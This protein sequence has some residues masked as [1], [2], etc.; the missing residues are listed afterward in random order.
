MTLS[1]P[2]SSIAQDVEATAR[3]AKGADPG[4]P[5][6]VL[7][8][9]LNYAPELVGCA[10][11][12]TEL[13]EELVARGHVV[14]V[15][16]APPYYPQWKI[17]EPYSGARWSREVRSG[18]TINRT[19]LYVPSA[20]SGVKRIL[21]LASFGAAALPTAVRA[22]KRFRPDLVFAVAPTLAAAGAALAAGKAAGAKTWLHVQDFEVDAAFGLGLLNNGAAR[23]LALGMENWL[24]RRFDRVSSIAPA[25][26]NLL[27]TKGVAADQA[28]ELR[29]W[30]DLDAFPT[31]VSSDTAYR[32]QLGIAADQI[33]ALYSGNMAG[34][35]GIEALADVAKSLKAVKAP[36]T[37]LLCGEGPARATLESAC[38]GLANVKFLPLQPLERLPEL[39]AT[40]DIHLLPQRAEAAD[41][42]LP[43]KLTGML[44]S[45]RPVVAMATQ[46]TGLAEEVAGCGLVVEPNAAAMTEGVL[47]LAADADLCRALGT[48]GKA[49]AKS[50]W[51]KRAIIDG[52][53]NEVASVL[54]LGDISVAS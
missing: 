36:V 49:R 27:R 2:L 28:L 23:R 6:R 18:V 45:G 9:A 29:N 52:F 25:M 5:F 14:E 34:K 16:A 3:A 33:V 22:A 17:A 51:R 20:P 24:L 48:A 38:Q 42:V 39:L 44:A 10:K 11:Y 21:H 53:V 30:V 8:V 7:I 40:A 50:R 41:L 26:V 12:T 13:A 43:S 32:A 15:V 37:L 46:G 54:K 47:T 1:A 4:R 19:P 35:Q 31:W